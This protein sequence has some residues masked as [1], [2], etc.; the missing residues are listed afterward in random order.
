MTKLSNKSSSP[1]SSKSSITNGKSVKPSLVELNS[2]KGTERITSTAAASAAAAAAAVATVNSS[3]QSVATNTNTSNVVKTKERA[4]ERERER[5]R[6][7]EKDK[8]REKDLTTATAVKSNGTASGGGFPPSQTIKNKAQLK[9][10]PKHIDNVVATTATPCVSETVKQKS[11]TKPENCIKEKLINGS[12]KS[13]HGDGASTSSSSLK[14][15]NRRLSDRKLTGKELL[16]CNEKTELS[17][18]LNGIIDKTKIAAKEQVKSA[19]SIEMPPQPPPLP[20]LPPIPVL[21][22]PPPPPPSPPLFSFLL[23]FALSSSNTRRLS[24]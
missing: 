23:S 11:P 15:N 2:N 21:E 4:G 6:E 19:Q 18:N 5:E 16:S 24:L 7:K 20:P 9:L 12:G 3:S 14:S 1:S 10:L 17:N 8:E 22:P 13:H